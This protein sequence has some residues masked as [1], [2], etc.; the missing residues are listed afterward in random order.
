MSVG[1]DKHRKHNTAIAAASWSTVTTSS[2]LLL[3]R[4][5]TSKQWPARSITVLIL[6]L[7]CYVRVVNWMRR[8]GFCWSVLLAAVAVLEFTVTGR[9]TGWCA[10]VSTVLDE[11]G[12]IMLDVVSLDNSNTRWRLDSI[13]TLST[14]YT[15]IQQSHTELTFTLLGTSVKSRYNR[16]L[17]D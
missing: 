17:V 15:W 1:S 13:S 2:C 14:V 4:T 8:R 5:L 9:D 10:D 6:A 7:K 3:T 16:T 12:G 11:G